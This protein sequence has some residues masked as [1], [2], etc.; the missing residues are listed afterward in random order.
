MVPS[1]VSQRIN[2]F[3]IFTSVV[4]PSKS[5]NSRYEGKQMKLMLQIIKESRLWLFTERITVLSTPRFLLP[6]GGAFA[7][8]KTARNLSAEKKV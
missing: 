1:P 4:K 6:L 8:D 5:I 2:L 7:T 3:I